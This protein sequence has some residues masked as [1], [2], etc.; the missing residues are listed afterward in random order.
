[1]RV[2]RSTYT[3]RKGKTQETTRWYVEFQ[4]QNGEPKRLAGFESEDATEELGRNLVALVAYHQ[5]SGGQTDPA[6]A[7]WLSVLPRHMKER[8]V[9]IGLVS[10]E[11]AAVAKPLVDQL[12]DFRRTLAAKGN[13]GRHVDL[14][15]SRATKVINDCGFRF[16]SDINGSRIMEHLGELRRDKTVQTKDGEKVARGMSAQTFNFYLQAIKQFCRWM[17]KDRRA[18][19]S[20]VAHLDGL[21][22]RTDRRRDR[23]AL[24]AD[25]LRH[26]L[27]TTKTGPERF[28]MTGE[29]RMM[30]YRL[31]AETGLRSGELRSLTR[32]SFS[33][34][35]KPATVTVA[36]AYSKHRRDDTLPLR[37]D[38]AQDLGIFFS[39]KAPA[40]PAFKMPRREYVAGMFKADLDAAGIAQGDGS[41]RRAD[42]HALRHTFISNL[43]SGGV[44]P[45]V[46]QT[47]ARHSDINLTMS[48]YTHTFQGDEMAA[49]AAL[50]DLDPKVDRDKATNSSD[51]ELGVSACLG[52]LLG[53][54]RPISKHGGGAGSDRE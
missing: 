2:Y 43:A 29:E 5:A 46:A 54:S 36:A 15:V 35:S 47:L 52:V 53:V 32:A 28:G 42:F 7:V 14:L 20:P 41:G 21:N 16:Y 22:V 3:D 12:A 44:H 8:L 51:D 24:A 49:L 26:V 30:L 13:T 33:L 38:M 1:M 19:E 27:A 25:E 6:L 17:V 23:R 9:E 4:D 50:P 48:R 39:T 45:K 40:T 18:F 37:P 31:A 11:R 10:A 34:D